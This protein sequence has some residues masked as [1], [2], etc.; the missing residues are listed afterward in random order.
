MAVTTPVQNW[1]DYTKNRDDLLEKRIEEFLVE[2]K[3]KN[4]DK[5]EKCNVTDWWTVY[6][7]K[8]IDESGIYRLKMVGRIPA[9]VDVVHKVLFDHSLR[10]TWDTVIA[11]IEL[12]ET[13]PN[14]GSII[15]IASKSPF[16]VANRDFVHIR[17]DKTT[18]KGERIVV[19]I[20][21]LHPKCPEKLDFVRAETIFSAGLLEQTYIPNIE[22]KTLQEGTLYTTITQ[23][24]VKG[25]VPK[26][27]VNLFATQVTS[28]WFTALSAACAAYNKGELKPGVYNS[29]Q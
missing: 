4:Q 25:A 17:S 10:L 11:S 15:Y 18:P 9:T 2:A 22:T 26:T 20:S 28:A 24:D 13:L 23:V 29:P 7:S 1:E 6:R 5:W 3:S 8:D 16:G 19:D 12:I 14:G 27:I 21:T